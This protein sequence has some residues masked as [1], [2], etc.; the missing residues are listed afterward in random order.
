MKNVTI[1]GKEYDVPEL[2]NNAI[3]ELADNGLDIFSKSFKKKSTLSAARAI[4]AWIEGIDVED[5]GEEMQN[6]II[7]GGDL[8]ELLEAF[9]TAIGESGF[10]NALM[11]RAKA[12]RTGVAPQDHRRKKQQ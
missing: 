4:I 8:Q 5:A 9:N 1:N 6:H 12:E 7:N 11:T 10:I 2:D 3:I